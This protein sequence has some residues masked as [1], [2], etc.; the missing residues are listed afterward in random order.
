[1][2]GYNTISEIMWFRKKAIVIPRP[3]PSAEQTMRTRL[4]AAR[5]LFNTIHPHHLTPESLAAALTERIAAPG[6]IDERNLPPLDG[7]SQ[8][9]AHM[10][11]E[12]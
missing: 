9:A 7:A 2:A 5:G 10:L 1:M 8:A 12:V 3:G 4:M 6:G 11:A